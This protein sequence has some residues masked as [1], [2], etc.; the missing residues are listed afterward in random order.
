MQININGVVIDVP[1]L[2]TMYSVMHLRSVP[3]PCETCCAARVK[4]WYDGARDALN[5]TRRSIVE[6]TR[7]LLTDLDD[8]NEHDA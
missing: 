2:T 4:A 3:C 7:Q 8:P 6:L 5:G 1:D